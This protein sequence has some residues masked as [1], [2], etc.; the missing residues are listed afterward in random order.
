MS[1]LN[2]ILRDEAGATSL[3]YALICCLLGIGLMTALQGLGGSI[4]STM[5]KSSQGLASSAS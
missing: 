2:R 1:L 3:E 4:A 5:Y